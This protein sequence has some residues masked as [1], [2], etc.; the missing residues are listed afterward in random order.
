M[1]AKL[2]RNFALLDELEKGEKGLSADGVSYGLADDNDNMMSN[3]KA[4]ILGI[5]RP[6]EGRIYEIEIYCGPNYPNEPPE[7]KFITRIN[8]PCVKSNGKVRLD[9]IPQLQKWNRNLTMEDILLA[10]QKHMSD[11]KS[12]HLVQPPEGSKF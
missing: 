5:Q 3:W 4:T 11:E 6:H 8:L 10:L 12:R 2:P 7:V 1:S 9:E